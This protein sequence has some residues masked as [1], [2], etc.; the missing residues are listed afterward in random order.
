MR[1]VVI[2]D[3]EDVPP[4]AQMRNEG[5]VTQMDLIRAHRPCLPRDSSALTLEEFAQDFKDTFLL[6][7]SEISRLHP[8]G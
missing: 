1:M 7:P 2:E 3:L 8:T 4:T 5:P 6:A